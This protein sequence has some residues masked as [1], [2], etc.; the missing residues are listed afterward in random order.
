VTVTQKPLESVLAATAT[1]SPTESVGAVTAAPVRTNTP[2]PTST[3]GS[4]SGTGSTPLFALLIG[5]AFASLGLLAVQAQRR[6]LRR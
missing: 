2:P 3:G 4:S 6:T 5:L 1:P